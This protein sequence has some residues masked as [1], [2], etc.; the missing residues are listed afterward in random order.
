MAPAPPGL[1]LSVSHIS[2]GGRGC[3]K[4]NCTPKVRQKTFGVQFKTLITTQPL[5][6]HTAQ[7]IRPGCVN[8]PLHVLPH[9]PESHGS[10]TWTFA[11][12]PRAFMPPVARK[13]MRFL[14]LGGRAA[15]FTLPY[16]CLPEYGSWN[17][18]NSGCICGTWEGR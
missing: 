14:F 2:E 10:W 6:A 9:S 15:A 5:I 11:P 4:M 7:H 16:C 3:V 18:R 1:S 12:P 8:S 17:R 13:T